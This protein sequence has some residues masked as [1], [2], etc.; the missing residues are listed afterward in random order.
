M[1][2]VRGLVPEHPSLERLSF[3]RPE[4]ADSFYVVSSEFEKIAAKQ[5]SRTLPTSA[6]FGPTGYEKVPI[7]RSSRTFSSRR[8]HLPLQGLGSPGPGQYAPPATTLRASPRPSSAGTKGRSPG[9]PRQE[10]TP[11]YSCNQYFVTTLAAPARPACHL[12]KRKAPT[13]ST[14]PRAISKNWHL[15]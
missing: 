2:Y 14:L 7:A 13:P 3:R 5:K 12:F 4:S 11:Q 8:T 9:P 1:S 10:Y 15:P 6:R